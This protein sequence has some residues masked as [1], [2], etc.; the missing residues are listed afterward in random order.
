MDDYNVFNE[1]LY[2]QLCLEILICIEFEAV[3]K[4]INVSNET[5][6]EVMYQKRQ[7]KI[8][9]ETYRQNYYTHKS[10]IL[11]FENQISEARKLLRE[12]YISAANAPKTF[13]TSTSLADVKF[14]KRIPLYVVLLTNLTQN[15]LPV[16]DDV[17]E[18]LDE[19]KTKFISYIKKLRST[20]ND[21]A[22]Y[23]LEVLH[24]QRDTA[25]KLCNEYLYLTE[26]GESQTFNF[27][28]EEIDLI[29]DE[30][31]S[32]KNR[33]KGLYDKT[34]NDLMLERMLKL[35]EN[36]LKK[37]KEEKENKIKPRR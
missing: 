31:T 20:D 33:L 37:E 29:V 15:P 28:I 22:K 18:Q 5:I 9:A 34:I 30:H 25:L 27:S 6:K 23:C 16:K 36:K 14:S 17:K 11:F 21:L 35:K 12:K 13:L 4:L 26:E 24:P 3:Y 7:Q 1:E 2:T 19:L 10:V 8:D 32:L